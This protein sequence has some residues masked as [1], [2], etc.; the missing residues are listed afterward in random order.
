MD[1]RLFFGLGALASLWLAV[2]AWAA[3]D[4]DT[5]PG[6][7]KLELRPRICVLAAADKQC[8]ATVQASWRSTHD[9]SLCLVILGRPEVKRCWEHSSEG[10]YTV[11]LTFSEDLLFQ[12]RDPGLG[13]TFAAET[14]RVIR[15]AVRYRHKRREPWNIFD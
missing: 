1:R 11:E 2:P 13:H 4:K 9:E 10:N 7:I 5:A 8:D 12:L 14:L 3:A 15:E 6:S